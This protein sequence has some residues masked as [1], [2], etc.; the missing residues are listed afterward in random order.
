MDQV[1]RCLAMLD[2]KGRSQFRWLV[3]VIV[4]N[5]V[6]ELASV[7]MILPFIAVLNDPSLVVT[8]PAVHAVYAFFGFQS[9]RSFLIFLGLTLLAVILFKN[10]YFFFVARAQAR[11]CHFQAARSAEQL[12]AG[13]LYAPYEVHLGRNSA[14]FINTVD[15]AVDQSFSQVMLSFLTLTTEIMASLFILA[16][17]LVAE[18]LLT[19]M[20]IAV[21]G[22][23]ALT[24]V[25]YL[26]RVLVRLGAE[27]ARF[28]VGRLQNLQQALS[29][30][31]DIKVLGRELF[32]IG[33]FR[34]QRSGHAA[35]QSQ[36]ETLSQ[37]PRQ[38][39]ESV[40]AGGL[41]LCIVIVL[42]QGRVSGELVSVLA[43]FA[44]AAFRIMP[45]IN[46]IVNSYNTMRH[47]SA[48]VAEASRDMSDPRFRIPAPVDSSA[49]LG[50]RNDIELKNISFRYADTEEPVLRNVSLRIRRGESVGIVGVSGA[51][52]ST[53]IDVVL[54]LLMPQQGQ[55]L[56]DGHDIAPNPA[57]WRRLVGYVP[58]TIALI[59]DT[60]RRNIAFGIDDERI[61]E[62]LVWHALRLARLLD[63]SRSLPRGLETMLGERG[64][65]L[66][67]GQRQRVGIARALYGEPEVLVFD[68]ATSSLD[69]E[70]E[71]EITNAIDA[72]Q[73]RKTLLIIA[74]RLSTVKRCDRL[75]LMHQGRVADSGS[76]DELLSRNEEF[77]NMV[78]LTE[79]TSVAPA[80]VSTL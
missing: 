38:V 2:S 53:L 24:L 7:G 78:R 17:L 10:I 1:R 36:A 21:V 34:K 6:V 66:S 70:S 61:D 35:V 43:L 55:V 31:K 63:F 68:E 47:A 51:G 71:H 60:L 3:V 67:G 5:G 76:F 79:L 29:S 62:A 50:F 40:V 58:Q 30:V 15:H 27:A 33:E 37:T 48:Y 72:L 80:A 73:G 44:M 13:Y 4:L 8:Q 74:H 56:I 42:M 46:R 69:N 59:D 41:V 16:L 77:R 22:L 19:L 14:S 45:G 9:P 11:F 20:L 32:F 57:P 28:R 52:K 23:S 54:G 75:V 26:R 12:L 49:Q 64:I 39:L 25:L 18:P 65:R